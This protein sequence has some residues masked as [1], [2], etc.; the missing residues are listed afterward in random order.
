MGPEA[1]KAP[2]LPQ[3]DVLARTD[4]PKLIR[5]M[6]RHACNWLQIQENTVDSVHTYYLHGHMSKVLNLPTIVNGAYFYRPIES[7]DWSTSRWGVEKTIVYGG[8]MPEIEVRPPLIFPNI[9]RIPE[10]PMEA[11]HFRIPVDDEHTDIIWIGLRPE[12]SAEITSGRGIP[13]VIEI[14]PPNYSI[15]N[16]NLATFYGQDRAVWETQGAIANR[17]NETLGASDRG[18]VMFRRMLSEQIDRVERGESPDVGVVDDA[19]ENVCIEFEN[20]TRPWTIN[21]RNI[22]AA[23]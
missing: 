21:D 7:Y 3:W 8:E 15:E 22:S 9:L 11:L 17:S 18:I 16:V 2:L 20:G 6:P 13:S 5:V 14:D 23:S 1:E 10:G 19:S 12:G 4:R